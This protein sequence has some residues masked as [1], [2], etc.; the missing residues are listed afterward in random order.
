MKLVVKVIPNAKKERIEPK[1]E[2]LKIYLNAPALEGRANKRLIEVLADYF[3]TKKSNIAI[4]RGAKT[5]EKIV[6][7]KEAGRK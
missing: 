5:R 7:I 3:D 6:E 4:I 2:V 1:G